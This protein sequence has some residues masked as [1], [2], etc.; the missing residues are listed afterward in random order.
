MVFWFITF[1]YPEVLATLA[2]SLIVIVVGW[3][4]FS[5]LWLST[6]EMQV[7]T[8]YYKNE[9]KF[10]PQA[11][12]ITKMR[13]LIADILNHDYWIK[14]VGFDGKFTRLLL[15]TLHAKDYHH[16]ANVPH[17]F[18]FRLCDLLLGRENHESRLRRKHFLQ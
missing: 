6:P 2:I 13:V 15:P 7:P 9:Y 4:L 10:D 17:L 11:G 16:A 18:H 3:L 12:F 1:N 14:H 8:S 5:W